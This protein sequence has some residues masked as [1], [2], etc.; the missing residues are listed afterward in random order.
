MFSSK[1]VEKKPTPLGFFQVSSLVT[2]DRGNDSAGPCHKQAC[3]RSS[4]RERRPTLQ[5]SACMVTCIYFLSPIFLFGYSSYS[6]LSIPLLD[7]RLSE[8]RRGW[9]QNL[10]SSSLQYRY[11]FCLWFE[12]HRSKFRRVPCCAGVYR[13]W[14]QPFRPTLHGSAFEILVEGSASP[15]YKRLHAWC[16]CWCSSVYTIVI[17]F[18]PDLVLP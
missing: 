3:A 11:P 2:G 5:T 10:G 14:G 12:F 1:L 6:F 7:S 17:L 18:A 9:D 16:T 8:W 13:W 4:S 15:R